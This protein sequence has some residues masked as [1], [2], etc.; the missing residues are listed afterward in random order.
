M[1]NLYVHNRTLFIGN[2]LLILPGVDFNQPYCYEPSVQ[3]RRHSLWG[4]VDAGA[5]LCQ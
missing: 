4:V 3:H 2:T 5:G 1:N